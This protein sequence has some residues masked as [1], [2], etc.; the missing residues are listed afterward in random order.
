MKHHRIHIEHLAIQLP[1]G[2]AGQARTLGAGLGRDIVHQVAALNT[3]GVG[4]RHIHEVVAE[5]ATV[6][7][8]AMD[9]LSERIAQQ[10]AQAV[11]KQLAG[12]G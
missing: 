12:K 10:V 4:R 7:N 5:K 9:S 8:G 2:L 1:R 11:Q 6:P 3:A